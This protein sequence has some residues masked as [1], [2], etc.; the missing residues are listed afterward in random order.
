M[1]KIPPLALGSSLSFPGMMESE[2]GKHLMYFYWWGG[3]GQ[4]STTDVEPYYHSMR[5]FSPQLPPTMEE[6]S[7]PRGEWYAQWNIPSPSLI[8]LT[9]GPSC[10]IITPPLPLQFQVSGLLRRRIWPFLGTCMMRWKE[11]VLHL[12]PGDPSTMKYRW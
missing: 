5:D 8:L 9:S 7:Y 12:R 6:V 4:V 1:T 3:C 2:D 11:C 10:L